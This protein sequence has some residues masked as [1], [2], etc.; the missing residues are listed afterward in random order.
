MWDTG[1]WS[2]EVSGG[3]VD[4]QIWHSNAASDWAGAGFDPA[5]FQ[6]LT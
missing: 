1:S 5:T 2:L 3:S 4:R 6:W